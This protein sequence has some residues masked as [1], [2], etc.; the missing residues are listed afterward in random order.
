MEWLKRQW[1]KVAAGCAAIALLAVVYFVGHYKKNGELDFAAAKREL[2]INQ[3]RGATLEQKLQVVRKKQGEI[4]SDIL[5][6]ELLQRKTLEANRELTD[7]EVI[8]HLRAY[9]LVKP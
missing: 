3:A 8:A 4:V 1:A 5:A 6:E 9:G 2:E 7:D